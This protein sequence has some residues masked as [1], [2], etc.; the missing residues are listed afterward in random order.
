[1]WVL[2]PGLLLSYVLVMKGKTPRD[3]VA[4]CYV[5]RH[6]GVSDPLGPRVPNFNS[7]P[8]L[9]LTLDWVS[10]SSGSQETCYGVDGSKGVNPSHCLG[11]TGLGF[12]ALQCKV[13]YV[14]CKHIPGYKRLQESR[15]WGT[16]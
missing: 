6:V 13:S 3:I 4:R 7:E 10:E 1:M 9:V 12:C 16:F 14:I 15:L 5:C 8:L 11:C 2:T